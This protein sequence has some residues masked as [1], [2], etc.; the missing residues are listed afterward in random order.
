MSWKSPLRDHNSKRRPDAA[1]PIAPYAREAAA[2]APPR[3]LHVAAELFPW[4]KTGGLGDVTAA[5]PPAL[6][7]VGVDARIVLPGFTA[8]LDAFRL[9]EVARL[10]TPF[11][12]ERVRIARA[13]LP[14]SPVRVYLID[15]PAFYDRPGTPYQAPDGGEWGDNHRRFALLGWAAAALAEGADPEWRPEILHG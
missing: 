13:Q 9:E 5:L 12:V 11:T 10:H 8:L 7:A 14:G 6:A 2:P 4:V 15:H 3:V 1:D